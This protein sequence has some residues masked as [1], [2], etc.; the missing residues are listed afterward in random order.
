MNQILYTIESQEETNRIKS[1]MLF[2][3]ITII[4]FGLI[5]VSMGGYRIATAK[6]AKEE[7][8]EAATVPTVNLYEE[9]NKLKINISHIRE[10]KDI[11]YSWNDGEEIKLSVY[12][13]NFNG[14]LEEEIDLPGG[15]NKINLKVIDSKGKMAT[16]SGEFTYKGTYMDLS[17]IDNKSLKIIVTDML[18][19]QSVTYQWNTEQEIIAYPNE[20]NP[21]RVEIVSEIPTGLNTIKIKAVNRANA[22]E[23]KEMPV[24]GITKP[25]MQINYN[26]DRTMLTIKL[27][28]AQ[29][30]ESYSYKLSNAPISEIAENGNIRED[31]KDKLTLVTSQTKQGN[32]QPSITE[33]VP[34]EQGFNYLEVTIR[35]IEGVEETFSG[36]CAK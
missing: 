36:W 15:T 26:S 4:I 12:S 2:F 35:N 24:K 30:I 1:V 17:V 7:A 31:F 16:V 9:N 19:L 22:V 6:V 34:F 13:E 8:K 29:G 18:G 11:I 3:A 20:E 25:T 23:N 27:N 10:I 14:N 28:D 33:Q 32:E 21:E 5:M